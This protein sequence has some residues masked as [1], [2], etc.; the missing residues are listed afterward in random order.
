MAMAARQQRSGDGQRPEAHRMTAVTDPAERAAVA[1]YAASCRARI[2]AFT[3]RHYGLAGTLRLHREALGLDLLRAPLNVLLVGPSLFLRLAGAGLRRLGLGR[4]GTWLQSRNLFLETRL[5]RRVADLVLVEL[6]GLDEGAP[7][8]VAWRE[9]ARHLIAEYVAARHAVAELAAVLVLLALGLL[10]VHA[11][12]PSAISLGPMLA[13]ELAQRAAVEDFWLGPAL[14]SLYYAWFPADAGW[15]RTVL[16]T[17]AVMAGF[18]LLATFMGLVTD[19][20]QEWLGLHRQRLRRLVDTLERVGL[21]EADARLSLPDP[22]I[23]RMTDLTD[24][25]LMAMRLTR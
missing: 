15:T 20:L 1:A 6:L 13:K 9:R 17:L 5:S 18:A 3:A 22:W 7:G 16:T 11:L 23:A 25:V 14:G 21:G 19:P 4:L 10:L 24:M 8:A 12:T 2:P